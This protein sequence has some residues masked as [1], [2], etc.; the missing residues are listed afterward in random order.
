MNGHIKL[1]TDSRPGVG[2]ALDDSLWEL[3]DCF[4]RKV[5][6]QPP[7]TRNKLVSPT[8]NSPEMKSG[9]SNSVKYVDDGYY[10]RSTE[11]LIVCVDKKKKKS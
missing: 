1:C 9:G 3:M 2:T 5:F 10:E 4:P 6:T 8:P 7:T 11:N